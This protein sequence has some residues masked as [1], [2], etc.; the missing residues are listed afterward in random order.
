WL[1]GH[2]DRLTE[3]DDFAA[4]DVSLVRLAV[5]RSD[6]MIPVEVVFRSVRIRADE[7]LIPAAE[8]TAVSYQPLSAGTI[9]GW[10]DPST[11]AM[12]GA[13][14]VIIGSSAWLVLRRRRS[15]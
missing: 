11:L 6:P 14:A 7:L 9:Q 8:Q 1:D 5:K 4:D 10:V 3:V 12:L 2:F 15:A 13:I